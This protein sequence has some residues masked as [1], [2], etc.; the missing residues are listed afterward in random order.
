MI[1]GAGTCI[2]LVTFGVLFFTTSRILSATSADEIFPDNITTDPE[3]SICTGS[4]GKTSWIFWLRPSTSIS[5][6][7]S[8]DWL[9]PISSH[10]ISETPPGAL[11][12][13]T[14][15]VGLTTIASAIV[16]SAN[17][18]RL[19]RFGDVIT[20]ERPTSR[21]STCGASDSC[22]VCPGPAFFG[23]GGGGGGRAARGGGGVGA[24]R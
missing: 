19:I 9:S 2:R 5:T 8:N 18:T 14:T 12:F 20:N 13:T 15:W 24:H 17:D 23:G 4:A 3:V 7:T 22:T 16:G 1:A 10:M 6:E 11:P 21:C